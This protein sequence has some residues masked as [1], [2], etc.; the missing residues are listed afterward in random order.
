MYP[1]FHRVVFR[2]FALEFADLKFEHHDAQ[3]KE[4]DVWQGE[5]GHHCRLVANPACPLLLCSPHSDLT[6]NTCSHIVPSPDSLGWRLFGSPRAHGP[7]ASQ[8]RND[9]LQHRKSL[10]VMRQ[11]TNNQH[12][13]TRVRNTYLKPLHRNTAAAA[14]A[15]SAPSRLTQLLTPGT[16]PLSPALRWTVQSVTAV[17]RVEASR[18]T[19]SASASRHSTAVNKTKL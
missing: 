10:A 14:A 2:H 3:G 4:A 12:T 15:D 19:Q 8:A 16:P 18:T 7:A 6:T 13:Y 17:S 5:H 9:N 1:F 11:H